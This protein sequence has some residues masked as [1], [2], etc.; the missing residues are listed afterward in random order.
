MP[1]TG[2]SLCSYEACRSIHT[3][4]SPDGTKLLF[5]SDRSGGEKHLVVC[6][7]QKVI[8]FSRK[9]TQNIINLPVDS[10]GNY[11]VGSRG[12]RNFKLWLFP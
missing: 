9:E 8:L 10:D 7:R 11:V 3:Q 4:F 1:I 5:I 6:A 12:I 2:A